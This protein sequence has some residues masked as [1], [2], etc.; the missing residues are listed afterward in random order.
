[1]TAPAESIRGYLVR[2]MGV[3][4]ASLA[5]DTP[6]FSSGLLDSFAIVDLMTFVENETGIRFDPSDVSLD[7]LDS[8]AKIVA[9]VESRRKQTGRGA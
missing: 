9:Y 8:V 4:G 1:M 3:D 7:N 5:D 6:L 2:D